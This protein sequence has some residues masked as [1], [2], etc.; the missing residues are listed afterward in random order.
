M[1]REIEW[2]VCRQ[3]KPT[4]IIMVEITTIHI[5]TAKLTTMEITTTA[6]IP[7]HTITITQHLSQFQR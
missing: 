2:I 6:T 4:T 5:R 3:Q 7:T 1:K